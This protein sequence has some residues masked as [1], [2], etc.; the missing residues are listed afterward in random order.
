MKLLQRILICKLETLNVDIN[1]RSQCTLIFRTGASANISIV[2]SSTFAWRRNKVGMMMATRIIKI[3]M[4]REGMMIPMT[5]GIAK[6]M[7]M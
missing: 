4:I 7:G 6:F 5:M 2:L 3:I 1:L